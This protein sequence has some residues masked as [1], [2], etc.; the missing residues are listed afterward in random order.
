MTMKQDRTRL[1]FAANPI[2]HRKLIGFKELFESLALKIRILIASELNN[3][4]ARPQKLFTSLLFE[5]R[6]KIT[7]LF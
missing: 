6:E 4:V 7:H 1:F 2:S 5:P 3:L